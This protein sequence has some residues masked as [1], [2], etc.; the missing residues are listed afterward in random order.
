MAQGKV[1]KYRGHIITVDLPSKTMVLDHKKGDQ[2]LKWDDRTEVQGGT[3][4]SLAPGQWVRNIM[5]DP[6]DGFIRTIRRFPGKDKA[7]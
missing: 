7:E 5:N 1:Q 4:E 3:F 6:D 2:V